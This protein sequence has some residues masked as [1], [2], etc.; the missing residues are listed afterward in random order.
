MATE[1]KIT[2]KEFYAAIR[3]MVENIEMVGE[4]PADEVLNFID[5]T[6]E[7]L[8]A[9]AERAK[10]KAAEKRSEGDSLRAEVE[11][12]LSNE[13]QTIDVIAAQITGEDVTK[14]KITARLTQL[15]KADI[16]QKEQIK[17]ANGRKVMAYAL[18]G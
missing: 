5:K 4:I 10:E 16:A 13:L 17:D 8:D 9:K 18:K 12:V 15:V 14:S 2:K 11:N 3:L 1:K 7:Q 6:V